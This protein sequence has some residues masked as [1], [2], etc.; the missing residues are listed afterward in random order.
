MFLLE[1][2]DSVGKQRTI[3]QGPPWD[4]LGT[5][6]G[7]IRKLI[8]R[9]LGIDL[10]SVWLLEAGFYSNLY[11]AAKCRPPYVDM[12]FPEERTEFPDWIDIRVCL[13]EFFNI[14]LS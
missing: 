12:I 9:R 6:F 10:G 13:S 1:Q 8:S 14:Q 3:V 2:Y 4:H 11:T 5:I 7:Q